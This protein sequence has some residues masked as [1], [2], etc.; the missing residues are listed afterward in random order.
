MRIL[1]INKFFYRRGGV[2]AVFF[3]TIKGLR[4]RGHDVV[5]FATAH[6]SN[7][8][9]DYAAYFASELP[10]MSGKQDADVS[11]KIFKRLFRSKE[12]EQK[13]GAL[14][15]ATEPEVAHL[16]N[17][18]HHLSASTFTK[19]YELKIPMVLTVHDVFPLCP[20]H[21][22]LEGET[23]C[24]ECYKNKLYNCA[25]YRC[26]NKKFLPSVAGVLEA[27]YYRLKKIWDRIDLYICPSQF[28]AGKLVEWGFPLEKMRVAPNSFKSQTTIPQLGD[29]IVY[30]G[31]IHYEK[32]IKIL[33]EAAK[34]LR[35]YK[36]MIA[37]TGPED[38]WVQEF[39]R[40]NILSNI[41]RISWVGGEAWEKVMRGA[42]VIVMPSLFYENCSMGILEAMSYGRIVVAVDRGGNPELIKD[43]IS[44]FL[45]KPEDPADLARVIRRAMNTTDAEAAAISANAVKTVEQN[46]RPEDY[47]NKLETI[48]AEV[49]K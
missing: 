13:L 10:E 3:N 21:S 33:M 2:E 27:Y 20:N 24:E 46:H 48:Y 34:R 29:K 8:P 5:E 39:A 45:C 44:G 18:Y 22:L 12:I 19:L 25:R 9:S 36:V 11:W 38:R 26:V 30:L 42:K 47:F 6:P 35:D 15:M 17:I 40:K 16:H 7:L 32:G 28:M 1:Q 43:G 49:V 4:E 41:E 37:G 31:R 14:I 23:L